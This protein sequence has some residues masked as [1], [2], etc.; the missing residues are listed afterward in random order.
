[1]ERPAFRIVENRKY[2]WDGAVYPEEEAARTAADGYRASGFDVQLVADGAGWL[3][4]TRREAAKQ[5]ANG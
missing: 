2:M 5:A 4:F 3:V 1:M